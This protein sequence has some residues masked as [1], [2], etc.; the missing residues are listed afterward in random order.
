MSTSSVTGPGHSSKNGET[1]SV[2]HAGHAKEKAQFEKEITNAKPTPTGNPKAAAGHVP[3]PPRLG[4]EAAKK[5]AEAKKAEKPSV[6]RSESDKLGKHN[7]KLIASGEYRKETEHWVMHGGKGNVPDI[8]WKLHVSPSNSADAIK[9]SETLFPKL[10]AL[11]V[12]HKIA[13]S[14]ET[15]TRLTGPQHGKAITIYPQSETEAG[16]LAA[17]VKDHLKESGIT[18]FDKPPFDQHVTDGVSARNGVIHGLPNDREG[19]PVERTLTD[20]RNGQEVSDDR[21]K[22]RPDWV[23]PLKVPEKYDAYKA[24]HAGVKLTPT[25]E[26]EKRTSTLDK[27][28]RFTIGRDANTA[29]LESTSKAVS[30]RHAEVYRDADGKTHVADLNSTNGTTVERNGQHTPVKPGSPVELNHGDKVHVGGTNG[31]VFTMPGSKTAFGNRVTGLTNASGFTLGRDGT[32]ADV[33]THGETVSGSHARVFRDLNGTLK[34]ADLKSTN[35]TTVERNGVSLPV[36]PGTPMEIRPGDH[37]RVGGTLGTTFEVP[38]ASK[39]SVTGFPAKAA[40]TM[41]PG[42]GPP[43]SSPASAT[44]QPTHSRMAAAR[45]GAAVSAGMEAGRALVSGKFG[46]D[47]AKKIVQSGVEG[48]AMGHADQLISSA[49]AK[50]LGAATVGRSMLAGAGSASLIGAVVNAGSSAMEDGAKVKTGSMTAGRATADVAVSA[51]VGLA[52]G[53]TG[54]MAGAAIGSV[55]PVA[56]TAVGAVVG[57]GVGM[58]V[59]AVTTM[60]AENSGL[61]NAAREKLG[62]ALENTVEQP[63]KQ[64]WNSGTQTAEGV[65]SFWNRATSAIGRKAAEMQGAAS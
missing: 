44:T 1:S 57:F 28:D 63:L 41:N 31:E 59:S 46:T 22:S 53:A 17:L 8:G 27:S 55:I 4:A 15:M 10:R 42:A 61:A 62:S 32:K 2:R 23:E 64:M 51:G 9:L 58:G 65:G 33:A 35:G 36:S 21:T 34:V 6:A 13:Q 40:V 29:D 7:D 37:I 20:P 47:E 48:A 19:N 60:V 16:H 38:G 5:A 11:G 25:Q 56:G 52:A 45:T 54:A 39:A 49:L 3:E 12:S 24:D 30:N 14:D 26:F 50:R 18:K 43:T